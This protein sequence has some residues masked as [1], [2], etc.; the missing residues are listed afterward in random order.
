MRFLTPSY[1]L[2]VTC[3]LEKTSTGKFCHIIPNSL[4]TTIFERMYNLSHPGIKATQKLIGEQ[5]VWPNM[6]R[7]IAEKCRSSISCQQTKITQHQVTPLQH[8]RT[9]DAR[10]SHVDVD[11]VG[12]L[13]DSSG[14]KYLLTVVDRLTRWPEAVPI[15]D[16]TAQSCADSFLLHWMAHFESPTIITTSRESQ[17]TSLL[18]TEM[19]QFFGS[20]L[21]HTTAFHPAA[22][23]L[24][25]RFNRSLKVA[26]KCQSPPDLWY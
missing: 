18:W 19:C 3:Y 11:I 15:K 25:E 20:K 4:R 10:F 14:Y 24:N 9:L 2:F 22:N 16:I 7:D 8:F 13:P 1:Y 5:F 12:L 23:G 6:R 21:C 26:L 17:F